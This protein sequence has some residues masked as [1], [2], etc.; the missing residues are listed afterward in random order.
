MKLFICSDIHGDYGSAKRAVDI[1]EKEGCDK[2]I[3]LGD[4]LYHGPRNDLPA[5]YAPKKVIEL[6]NGIKDKILTVRGNCDAEVDGM[7]LDF[8]VLTPKRSIT[9]DGVKMLLTHGHKYNSTTPPTMKKG[10][11]MLH[12]HT[13]VAKIEKFGDENISI[14][15]GSVAIPKDG[16]GGSYIIYENRVFTAYSF[17]GDVIFDIKV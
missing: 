8:P 14:N 10:E 17:N 9:A 7:V 11:I 1:F 3:V 13:H 15:P 6:L 2:F 12:G 16:T 5:T 4:L